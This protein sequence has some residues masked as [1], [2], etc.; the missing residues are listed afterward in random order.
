MPHPGGRSENF[1]RRLKEEPPMARMWM[2]ALLMGA[3]VLLLGSVVG[4]AQER[5]PIN[6][7]QADALAKSF[8]VGPNLA[9]A[10]TSPEF[11]MRGTIIDVGYGAAQDGLFTSTY[12][13]PLSRIRWEITENYLN[14]R[15]SYEVIANS[16]GKGDLQT[17]GG[18]VKKNVNDGQIVAS[19]KIS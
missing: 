19:Y 4:C 16:D 9:D 7:V 1:G 14:A 15:L 13:Q 17:N 5:A 18:L 6:Q 3:L 12:A 2:R 11:Y 8:F 10:S